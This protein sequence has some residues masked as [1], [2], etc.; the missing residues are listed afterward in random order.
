MDN[1]L[2]NA[3]P[4]ADWH[5][6]EIPVAAALS[7]YVGTLYYLHL[8]KPDPKHSLKRVIAMATPCLD[9]MI[10]LGDPFVVETFGDAVRVPD[11]VFLAGPRPT[12]T[13]LR[14][15]GVLTLLGVRFKHGALAP[16][17]PYPAKDLEQRFLPLGPLWP[18]TAAALATAASRSATTAD[19]VRKTEAALGQMLAGAK[20]PDAMVRK[21][22]KLM[23]Q[24][25]GDLEVSALAA[26]LGV[27]R[28]TVK[29]KFDQHVG[30]SPKLFG[31]LRR[32]Q[33]VLRRLAGTAK[34]DWTKLAQESGY[35]DQAHLIREVNHFTGFSPKKF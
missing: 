6:T 34:V 5:L 25:Q 21:A 17:I 28:Q 35:Y 20:Q 31:K 32:F 12:T 15:E 27:S 19:L 3:H 29:H 14:R 2:R 23:A 9:L 26:E 10:N 8:P 7:P 22:V 4:I 18:D 11:T 1:T 24:H 16:L 33:S 30:L 13:F